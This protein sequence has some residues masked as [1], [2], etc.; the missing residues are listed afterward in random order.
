METKVA[1]SP[2]EEKKVNFLATLDANFGSENSHPD[3]RQEAKSFLQNNA[4]PTTRTEA[5]KYTRVTKIVNDS[6]NKGAADT[7]VDALVIPNLDAW[8]VVFVNGQMNA[9]MSSFP[10]QD[11]FNVTRI[12]ENADLQISK[13]P[14]PDWFE[15]LNAAYFTDGLSIRVAK[16]VKTEKPLYIV[17]VSTGEQTASF[18]R[19]H[20]TVE[21][22]AEAEIVQHHISLEGGKTFLSSVLEGDVA[23]NAALHI[24]K[25]QEAEANGFEH[26][27]EWVD[28]AR[29]SHFDIRTLTLK[30]GWVRNN[31]NI[32]VNGSNCTT[33]L[34]GTYMPQDK[35][36]VD[37]HTMV[38]H[39]V[40]HCESNEVYKG[41]IDDKATGVFN[42]KV[43]VREDAQ[44]TNAYQQNANIVLSD[45]A[46]MNSKPELEIYADDVKCSH[47]STTGQFD[48][49]AVFY[50][51][52]RGI[53]DRTA[54]KILTQAFIRE[55]ADA[56]QNEAVQT[57]CL[58]AI[59]EKNS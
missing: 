54:R 47:G 35:E 18:V 33:N 14:T 44:K 10:D 30:G 3:F 20:V 48:E 32:N 2:A 29:D 39:R 5:W 50:L 42:G 22:S 8:R 17:H 25:V 26:S 16:K 36:H 37:N 23:Q 31:L 53:G 6:W 55:I 58:S 24:D 4:A 28:Q 49:E 40:P 52:A 1:L 59:E 38:D 7:S 45:D 27:V 57:Y 51:R 43:F 9:S 56:I 13:A 21:E 11:G 19:H 41:V 34:F 12:S 46:A 15:A